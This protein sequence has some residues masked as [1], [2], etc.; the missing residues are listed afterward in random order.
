YWRSKV[1]RGTATAPHPYVCV[2]G[3]SRPTRHALEVLLR[4]YW[5]VSVLSRSPLMLRVRDLFARFRSIEVGMAM[6]TLDDRARALLEPW[7]PP[8]EGRLRC[9]RALADAGL[10]TFV[11]FAPAYPP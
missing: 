4:A 7:A 1:L 10:T 5:P 11:G 8:I 2:A 3:N 9:L 6:P